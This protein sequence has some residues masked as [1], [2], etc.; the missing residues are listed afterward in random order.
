MFFFLFSFSRFSSPPPLSLYSNC[1]SKN[2]KPNKK[3]DKS[4]RPILSDSSAS[5]SSSS[6]K[7]FS[8][9]EFVYGEQDDEET[10]LVDSALSSKENLKNSEMFQPISAGGSFEEAKD[11]NKDEDYSR[12]NQ[13]LVDDDDDD[14]TNNN[15][16]DGDDF[17]LENLSDEDLAQLI[18]TINAEESYL[19]RKQRTDPKHQMHAR[20]ADTLA[21]FSKSAKAQK[22]FG[23]M[24][25][26]DE[27]GLD[28][29]ELMNTLFKMNADQFDSDLADSSE[30]TDNNNNKPKPPPPSSSTFNKAANK[31]KSPK[32]DLSKSLLS[33]LNSEEGM[34]NFGFDLSKL[35][36]GPSS[37]SLPKPAS[38]SK[39]ANANK[40][41]VF[42]FKEK[43]YSESDYNKQFKSA[44][45]M[46]AA[47]LT[48]E[49]SSGGASDG[50]DSF[51]KSS[52]PPFEI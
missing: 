50:S 10:P 40:K 42:N 18:D 34:K 44:S 17:S 31:N 47:M 11:D 25:A 19:M 33:I 45:S 20:F 23:N 32:E 26:N 2:Q 43:I 29:D 38:S 15:N 35:G 30:L 39:E 24:N 49:S 3:K 4:V 8:N 9:K 7:H 27:P 37:L 16:N 13:Q 41:P 12:L 28:Y 1:S 46:A 14:R 36:L 5:K 52:K 48:K 51:E 22:N 6:H 21:S